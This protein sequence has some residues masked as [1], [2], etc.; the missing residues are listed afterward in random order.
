MAQVICGQAS[1]FADGTYLAS[2][3]EWEVSFAPYKVEEKI[4]ALGGVYLSETRTVSSVKGK[5]LVTHA[6]DVQTIV[7]ARAATI[8]IEGNSG[9]VFQLRN[10]FYAGEGTYNFKSGELDIEFKGEGSFIA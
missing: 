4:D 6:G 5:I 3:G 7:N 9:I 8:K 10:A 1:F 2:E